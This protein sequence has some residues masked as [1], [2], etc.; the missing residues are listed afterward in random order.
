M[1]S[2][3]TPGKVMP[4]GPVQSKWPTTSAT[5]SATPLGVAGCGVSTLWRSR[6]RSPRS[7]S[8]GAPLIPDPPMST[9]KISWHPRYGQA[10]PLARLLGGKGGGLGAQVA[11]EL[12]GQGEGDRL[13][14]RL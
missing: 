8:T 2:V 12:L 3:T 5:P 13:V 4:T 9:P 11:A 6:A 10:G 7:R 14:G 1:P